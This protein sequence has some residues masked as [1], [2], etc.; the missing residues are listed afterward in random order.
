MSEDIDLVAPLGRSVKEMEGQAH[1][2]YL[3]TSDMR[4]NA[5]MTTYKKLDDLAKYSKILSETL[6]KFQ[7]ER[8]KELGLQS[9]A[10]AERKN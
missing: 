7:Q 2:V 5:Y 3:L 6:E 4:K 10:Y 1:N 9:D 8:L